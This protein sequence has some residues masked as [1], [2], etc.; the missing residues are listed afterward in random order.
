MGPDGPRYQGPRW[1]P[2]WPPEPCYRGCSLGLLHWRWGNCKITSMSVK[3]SWRI[4]SKIDLSQNRT[5][6]K[7]C[8]YFAL[9]IKM[10]TPLPKPFQYSLKTFV[11]IIMLANVLGHSDN[12]VCWWLQIAIGLNANMSLPNTNSGL[13]RKLYLAA[14]ISIQISLA[15]ATEMCRKIQV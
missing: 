7:S 14:G 11:R 1:A 13:R 10:I 6:K 2:C 5:K 4:R 12:T 8:V 15:I 9:N 3:S